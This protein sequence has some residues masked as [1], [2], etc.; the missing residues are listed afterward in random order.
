MRT[1]GQVNSPWLQHDGFFK[2]SALEAVLVPPQWGVSGFAF[3]IGGV[4][5]EAIRLVAGGLVDAPC[6]DDYGA[7]R[8]CVIAAGAT[9]ERHEVLRNPWGG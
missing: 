6:A 3:H 7:V 8:N 5:H 1:R 2:S 4:I 9:R